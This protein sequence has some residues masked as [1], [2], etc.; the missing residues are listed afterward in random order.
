M[1]Q[2]FSNDSNKVRVE[3][4]SDEVKNLLKK[5]KKIKKYMKSSV[6]TLKKMDGTEEIVSNLL[7]DE[8][9]TSEI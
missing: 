4:N 2:G 8:E 7:K 6:Y 9:K 5:Y 1:T 3:I